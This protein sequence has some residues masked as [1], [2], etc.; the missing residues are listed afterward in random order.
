MASDSQTGKRI[1]L[2]LVVAILAGGMLLYL[3]PQGPG[4]SDAASSDTVAKVGDQIVTMADVRQ[5]LAQIEQRSQIPKQFESIYAQNIL[6]QLTFQKELEY[7]AKRLGITVSD[8]ERADRIRQFLPTAFNG[9]SFVGMDRYSQEVSSRF[10]LTVPVFEELIRQGLLEEKFRQLVTDGISSSPQELQQEFRDRNEKVKL[11]YVLI[12]P[13][14]LELK[15]TPTDG[16]IKAAY[17]RN[18]AKYQLPE[19]RVV[20]YGLLDINQLRQNVHISDDQ[21][22]AQ[23]QQNIKDYEVPNRVHVQHILLMT[24]GKTDAEVEEIRKK[25]EDILKQAKKGANFSDLAKKYSEDPGSKDKGGDLGFI[26]QGQTVPEF[27]KTAFSLENGQISDLVKTQYGFHI[28]K[29]V[30][31]ESAHTKPFEEVRDSLRAP[32][33]LGEADKESS[34]TADKISA[35]ERRSSKVSFDDVAREF[36]LSVSETR[37]VSASDPLLELGNAKDVKD[38][39]FRLKLGEVSTPIRTDRGYV[40]LSIKDIQPAH[41]GSLEEVRDRVVSDIQR[42]KATELALI[43]SQELSRRVKAGEKF[44]VVAK[45]LSL[46]AKTSEPLARSGSIPG[47]GSGKQL[48]AAFDMKPGEV[49]A[50]MDLGANRVVYQVVSKDEPN[51]SDFDKQIKDLTQA[52]VQNKRTVA[53]DAFRS[54]LEARLKQEGK[55]KTYPDKLKIS[56]ALG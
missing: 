6:K 55:L 37:P 44:E 32:L 28:I 29:V 5:E 27:E 11:E 18:R 43:N 50:P 51:P 16:E 4:T 10:Q 13:E 39:I 45:S 40:V 34:D 35:E 53:F 1:L 33:M 2:G 52:V 47:V 26:V 25:A 22:K 48:S 46:D 12:K 56:S 24:V 30:E 41:Q 15:I 38:E 21:L 36:H 23:Y 20:R 3:V 17:E 19:R 31:K 8:Q 7:E 14:D 9:D 42:E 54:A 49:S